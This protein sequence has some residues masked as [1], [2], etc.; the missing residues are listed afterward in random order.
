MTEDEYYKKATLVALIVGGAL[1]WIVMAL[2]AI[3]NV[4]HD[5]VGAA[6]LWGLLSLIPAAVLYE[7]MRRWQRR[8]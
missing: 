1:A 6:W 3:W 5:D 7:S 4:Q 2:I 8:G